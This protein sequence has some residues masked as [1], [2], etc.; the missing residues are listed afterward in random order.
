MG[1]IVH[2]SRAL[3]VASANTASRHTAGLPSVRA[4]HSTRREQ[5]DELTQQKG[6]CEE[7][8]RRPR[9][10]PVDWIPLADWRMDTQ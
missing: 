3:R 1:S 7:R 8:A 10:A 6:E 2:T 4:E 9:S 5:M